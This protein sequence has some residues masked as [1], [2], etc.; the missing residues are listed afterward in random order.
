MDKIVETNKKIISIPPAYFC[1]CI[2][3][4][5]GTLFIP[6]LKKVILFP[7]NL[8]GILIMTGG[9]YLV[10]RT[11]FLLK[12]CDTTET[13]SK[14][15]CFVRMGLFKYSRNPMYLGGMIFLTGLSCLTGNIIGFISPIFFFFIIN[16]MFIPYEEEKMKTEFGQEY[17]D[18]KS[19]VRRWI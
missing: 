7:A 9:L 8:L 2:L 16:L 3:F 1:A 6:N 18:Y 5:V 14:S 19:K 12:K 10:S 17:L 13:Y 11:H 15:N 4:N